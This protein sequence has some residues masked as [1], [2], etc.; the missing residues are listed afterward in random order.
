MK[1]DIRRFF[2]PLNTILR[3]KFKMINPDM[4]VNNL[5]KILFI[6]KFCNNINY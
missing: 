1:F 5:L 6:I 3:S 4:Y 2:R